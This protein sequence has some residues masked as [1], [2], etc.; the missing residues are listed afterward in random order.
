MKAKCVYIACWK[1]IPKPQVISLAFC[2][3]LEL[4][5]ADSFFFLLFDFDFLEII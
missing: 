2:R 4:V 1:Y 3:R 5:I